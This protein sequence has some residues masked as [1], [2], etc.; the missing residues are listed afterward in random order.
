MSV[1]AECFVVLVHEYSSNASCLD[2]F[3]YLKLTQKQK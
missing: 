3:F 1:G 2:L